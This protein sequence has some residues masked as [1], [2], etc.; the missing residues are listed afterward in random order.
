MAKRLIIKRIVIVGIGLATLM[1][2]YLAATTNGTLDVAGYTDQLHKI[3]ELGGIGTYYATV[4]IHNNPFNHPPFM[5]HLLEVLGFLADATGISFRFWLRLVP[6]LA[7]V[8]SIILVWIMPSLRASQRFGKAALLCM[9]FCP[10]S[11]IISGY[12]GNTD[13]VFIFFVLLAIYLLEAREQTLLAGLAFGMAL[14]IKVVP[15][16]LLPMILCYLWPNLRKQLEFVGAAGIIFIVGSMPYLLQDPAIIVKRVFGYSSIYGLW[17]WSLLVKVFYPEF[18]RFLHPPYDVVGIHGTFASVGKWVMLGLITAISYRM[19]SW[20]R[21][22]FVFHQ[23]GLIV[24]IFLTFTPGFGY[25]YLVWL[26]PFVVGLGLQA[27]VIYYG[28]AGLFLLVDYTCFNN[29]F[30]YCNDMLRVFLRIA[31]WGSVIFVLVRYWR[32]L[33]EFK[34]S[35][36]DYKEEIV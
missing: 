30:F 32:T 24:A 27:T 22:P 5:I 19:N 8:G 10:I 16:M 33:A 1:K 23:A 7:D 36:K 20:H 35:G 2:L 4:A 11:I 21:R 29:H 25:Q 28:M 17:G 14:N 34:H 18:P 13:P 31:T 26:V 3:R 6:S 12:H 9:V 15:L